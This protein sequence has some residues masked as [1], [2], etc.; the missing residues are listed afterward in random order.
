VQSLLDAA[1]DALPDDRPALLDRACAGDP[2]LRAE[3]ASLLA[4]ADAAGFLE[5]SAAAFASPLLEHTPPAPSA[6][7]LAPGTIVGPYRIVG[8]LARGG[9]GAV[10]LAELAAGTS[11]EYV[12]LKL[13]RHGLGA[14]ITRRFLAERRALARLSHPHIARLLDGGVTAD[15]RPWLAVEYVEGAPITD[16]CDARRLG[17]DERLR[18]FLDVC[19]A[20]GHAHAKQIVH[21]D[22]K[23]A[24]ILVTAG[25]A[26]KLLDFGIARE[27]G[28]LPDEK[29]ITAAGVRVLTAEYAAPEQVRG[30][31]VTA[32]T[33]VYALGAVL[34]ELLTGRRAHRL[35]GRDAESLERAICD[36]APA[37][38]SV[39]VRQPAEVE[40]ADGRR[41]T[42]APEVLSAA[43][44]TTP[45]RLAARLCRHLDGITLTALR[46][47]PARRYQSVETLVADLERSGEVARRA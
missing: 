36:D 8:E 21:R 38:P 27:V 44:G 37:P 32:A 7:V 16:H 17:V 12:A 46:K 22:V 24:N 9:M 28:P 4:E 47:D 6:A 20:V 29:R 34:Y 26:V 5:S 13:V 19:A 14:D 23:P 33:D 45:D 40:H 10:Y 43:R 18:I 41:E 42:V 35:T 1:L 25:G 30:E 15:G 11:A 2:A 31:P 39:V 3:V